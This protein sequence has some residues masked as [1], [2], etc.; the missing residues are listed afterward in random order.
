MLSETIVSAGT[1]VILSDNA[2]AVG[3]SE[4][5]V[6]WSTKSDMSGTAL[7]P[8]S[9][10]AVNKDVSLH[11]V[12]TSSDV[13]MIILPEDQEG[14]TITADPKV[15]SRGGS[16]ILTYSLKQSHVDDE[17][18]ITVNGNPIKLDAMKRI[19]LTNI[20]SD[21]VVAVS[22]VFDKR[23]HSISIPKEQTGYVLTSSAEKV[24]HKQSYTLEYRLLPGYKE[25]SDFGIHINNG[26]PL[27]P[28]GGI[29]VIEDVRDNHDITVTGVELIQ[30]SISV[31]KNISVLVNGKAASTATIYDVIKVVPA[32]GYTIPTTFNGQIKGTFTV[33]QGNYKVLSNIS[34]PSVLK[35]SAGDNVK[36][37]TL[38]S[39]TVF[40]CPED[41]L[42]IKAADGYS[43]PANYV[44]KVKGMNGAKYSADS[45]TFSENVILPSIYKVV[46]NGYNKVHSTSYVVGGSEIPL[47]LTAPSRNYYLFEKWLI[48]S[49]KILSDT[50]IDAVWKPIEYV[51]S[52]GSNINVVING[53]SYSKPGSYTVTV[54]DLV[55]VYAK[56]GYQ[57]PNGYLPG[58]VFLKNG[59]GYNII[60]N[61]SL[62]T[63]HYVQYYDGITNLTSDRYYFSENEVHTIVNPKTQLNPSFNFD[64][65]NTS[66]DFADFMGWLYNG[67]LYS[68]NTIVVSADILFTSY[69]GAD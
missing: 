49:E 5:F 19:Y 31:G 60:S 36:I 11:A 38:G 10:L 8:G 27:K 47:P 32:D 23:E 4:R 44:E 22:G 17:L 7:L 68:S 46:F 2:G 63:I 28:I 50:T 40:V 66:Y 3:S 67:N 29:L 15:V 42:Q 30:Y 43:L 24:H 16:S 9:S 33:D 57:L 55:Y 18:N 64:L 51:I 39:K 48:S 1:S 59:S 61:Y 56:Q 34:F 35:I 25:T 58:S 26:N 20:N 52:F 6:G 45:F 54:E 37:G 13:F 69:W 65:N 12:I 41:K 62:P 21:Q 14:F 53:A